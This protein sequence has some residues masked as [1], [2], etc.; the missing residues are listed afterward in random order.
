MLY[1][2]NESIELEILQPWTGYTGC[3]FDQNGFIRQVLYKGKYT[4]CTEESLEP[5]KGSGGSGICNEF[6]IKKALGYYEV[7]EGEAFPKIG[8]GILHRN[9]RPYYHLTSYPAEAFQTELETSDTTI[10][11]HSMPMPC[12]GYAFDYRKTIS[13]TKNGFAIDYSLKNTGEKPIITDEYAHNF[14]AI[15]H[16][17]YDARYQ[18]LADVEDTKTEHLDYEFKNGMMTWE[19]PLTN[20]YYFA[21]VENLPDNGTFQWKLIHLDEKLG[22]SETVNFAPCGFNVWGMGHVTSPEVFKPIHLLPGEQDSWQRRY[23]I[24][25][26]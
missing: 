13:L 25:Q 14:L 23:E 15:N 26:F 22:I 19:H 11:F 8:V 5:G 3:R 9:E 16:K 17:E 20:P 18:L 7:G 10:T 4:F 24:F 2:K 1:L 21:A 12:N 6:G